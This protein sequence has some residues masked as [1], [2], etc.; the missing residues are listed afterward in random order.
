MPEFE[1]NDE[2]TIKAN[3]RRGRIIGIYRGRR[4]INYDVQYTDANGLVSDRYF[5][6]EDL[7]RVD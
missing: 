6:P 5:F 3:G 4:G 2:C 1:I 7:Q